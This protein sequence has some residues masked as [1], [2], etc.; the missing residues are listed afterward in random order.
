MV[1]NSQCY[2]Y[3]CIK[4]TIMEIITAREF[5]ANQTKYLGKAIKGEDI[6]LKSRGL[7]SFRL[8]PITSND[9]V[10]HKPDLTERIAMALREVKLMREGK[11][12]DLSMLELLD[13][14]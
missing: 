12:K 10:A 5:R 4:R 1:T 6:V 7:G 3:L 14:L 8:V 13:E 9:S 2:H 11:L